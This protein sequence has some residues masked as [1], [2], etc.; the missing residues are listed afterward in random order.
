MSLT[1]SFGFTNVVVSGHTVAPI[2]IGPVTNYALKQD[3]PTSVVMDN[4]TCPLDQGELLTYKCQ[5]I[6]KVT[7]SQLIHNPAKV[8]AGVQYVI[9]LEEILRTTSSTDSSFIVDEPV[10][11]YLVVRHQKSGN[12][13]SDI[14]SG[15][16]E[17]LLGA[18]RKEDGTWR[19]DE[20]M[21]SA[22]K[23]VEN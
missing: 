14:V 16:A 15:I 13:T 5:D 22:L 18:C 7:T 3:E 23:P 12:I 2:D 8:A 1:S 11:A 20:L 6:P 4:K 21:R 10:V 17:R 19:F 9:K